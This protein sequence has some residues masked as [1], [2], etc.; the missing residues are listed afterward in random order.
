MTASVRR[1]TGIYKWQYIDMKQ[2]FLPSCLSGL[3]HGDEALTR[4]IP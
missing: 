1:L 3:R 4:R 2:Y